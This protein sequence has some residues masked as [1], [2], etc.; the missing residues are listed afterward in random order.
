MTF[1]WTWL[2]REA[3]LSQVASLLMTFIWTW[4]SRE[5]SLSQVAS[6]LSQ[7]QV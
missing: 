5:A 4:L 2:S 6:L 3:S 1:I 7:V